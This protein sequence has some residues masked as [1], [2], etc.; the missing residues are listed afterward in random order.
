MR[1]PLVLLRDWATRGADLLTPAHC[2]FCGDSQ[3]DVGSLSG[4]R[5]P[6][7]SVRFCRECLQEFGQIESPC[8]RCGA[9]TPSFAAPDERCPRCRDRRYGFEQVVAGGPYQGRLQHA[10][11]QLKQGRQLTLGAALGEW[12]AWER[13]PL[14]PCE[15]YDLIAPTPTHWRRRYRRGC[16]PAEEIARPVARIRSIPLAARLLR[17]VRLPDKQGVLTPNQRFAN[18]RNVFHVRRTYDLAGLRVLLVDDVL[19][20]GATAGEAA[21]TLRRAGAARVDVLVAARGVG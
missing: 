16:N 18:V 12:L 6:A 20:T 7:P 11:L 5:R 8:L 15:S 10:I 17:L 3:L 9:P 14:L 13:W 1:D 4:G 19:T 21:R 2:A